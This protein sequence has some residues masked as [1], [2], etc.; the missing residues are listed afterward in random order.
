VPQCCPAEK[1]V[2]PILQIMIFLAEMHASSRMNDNPEMKNSFSMAMTAR[3][4]CHGVI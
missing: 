2:D 3:Q 4:D 1:K